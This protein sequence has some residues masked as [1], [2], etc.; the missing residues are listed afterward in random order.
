MTTPRTAVDRVPATED[1]APFLVPGPTVESDHPWVVAFADRV[2]RGLAPG[3]GALERAV[4]LYY[5]VRDEIRYDPYTAELSVEGLCA[6]RTLELGRGWCVSKAILLAAACRA[7]GIP[8]RLG[9]ADVRNHLST[10][11]MRQRMQT[12]MFYWHGYT[13]IHLDGRW[14]KATPAFNVELC[15]KFRLHPLEFDGAED[16]IYHPFDLSG[17]RHMEYVSYRGEFA[18]P[19]IDEIA[20]TFREHYPYHRAEEA[21][22]AAAAAAVEA[23][24]FDREV[25]REAARIAGAS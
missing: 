1:L 18:E 14:V 24:D 19:P 6:R 4:R 13:S 17:N 22:R 20:A 3:A 9:F 12:D 5:A 15:E 16:S 10:E 21:E 11:K 2:V 23:G 7:Q 25:D 8:A